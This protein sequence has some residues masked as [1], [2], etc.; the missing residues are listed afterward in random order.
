MLVTKGVARRRAAQVHVHFVEQIG[1]VEGRAIDAAVRRGDGQRAI[2]RIVGRAAGEGLGFE[3]ALRRT[4][5]ASS[6]SP[7]PVARRLRSRLPLKS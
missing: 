2:E 1:F 3:R 6:C 4:S 5:P 7:A